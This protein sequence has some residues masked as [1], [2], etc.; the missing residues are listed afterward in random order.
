MH[1]END[2]PS[3]AEDCSSHQSNATG[4]NKE[5]SVSD[6]NNDDLD[7]DYAENYDFA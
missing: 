6:S 5:G 2:K 4:V 3:V 1:N 7:D